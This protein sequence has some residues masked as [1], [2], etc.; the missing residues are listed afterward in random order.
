PDPVCTQPLEQLDGARG[1]DVAIAVADEQPDLRRARDRREV[2]PLLE[3]RVD[4]PGLDCDGRPRVE[5]R[6]R[7]DGEP[8]AARVADEDERRL[9]MAELLEP[10]AHACDD[11]V[12][13]LRVARGLLVARVDDVVARAGE[14]EEPLLVL[15]ARVLR[16]A[17]EERDD[18]LRLPFRT[19]E[20]ELPGALPVRPLQLERVSGA[21]R[22][23]TGE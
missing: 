1:A 12:A 13:R 17:V 11:A 15:K 6:R 5:E 3:R 19:H 16:E 8:A 14:V 23:A 21:A 4:P 10:R 9:R 7:L 2:G 20:P 18:R 22:A